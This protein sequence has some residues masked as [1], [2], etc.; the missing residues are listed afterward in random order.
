MGETPQGTPY[1][2]REYLEGR[3]LRDI[4]RTDALL[5]V[6][7]AVAYVAQASE[8]IAEA[9]AGSIRHPH[10]NASNLFLTR[11]RDGTPCVKTLDF[12]EDVAI[13]D[14]RSEIWE[15]GAVAYELLSGHAPVRGTM[16]RALTT[17]RADVPTG[18]A[19]IVET[20]LADDPERRFANVGELACAL[21]G[22]GTRDARESAAR[23]LR[24]LKGAER[25][26]ESRSDAR[27]VHIRRQ[28]PAMIATALFVLVGAGMVAGSYAAMRPSEYDQP[29]VPATA[30]AVTAIASSM[31]AAI[32]SAKPAPSTPASSATHT[33]RR[34]R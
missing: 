19:S 14:A 2:V 4:I 10:L 28:H 34:K 24:T 13:G 30:N 17:I 11:H 33:V 26:E 3:D 16:P 22:Y 25:A 9:H 27:E 7:T 20:A 29:L 23:A 21:A 12:A 31:R 8:A 5:T 18:L 6:E 1:L 32:P 15:L